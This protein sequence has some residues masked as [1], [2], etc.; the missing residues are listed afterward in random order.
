[1]TGDGRLALRDPQPELLRLG[2]QVGVTATVVQR[3]IRSVELGQL[4]LGLLERRD[5]LRR[6][7]QVD[8]LS[9]RQP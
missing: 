8:Q 2:L 5:Q 9:G 3:H 7:E 4:A 6:P 1:M